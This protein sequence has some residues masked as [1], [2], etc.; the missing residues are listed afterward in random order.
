LWLGSAALVV[1]FGT[2]TWPVGAN[3][4]WKRELVCPVCSHEMAAIMAG[5]VLVDRCERHGVWLDPGE[6]GR[7]IGAPEAEE[8]AAF[9]RHVAPG[10]TMPELTARQKI[11]E[12]EREERRR[13]AEARAA[14]I[15]NLEGEVTRYVDKV[16]RLRAEL[17][18]AEMVLAAARRKRE[19]AN[20]T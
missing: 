1:A 3:A 16:R 15:P 20:D 13:E 19:G 14:Q 6:L 10:E 12:Q 9:Y 17:E 11:R 4:W 8:L 2:R 18:S 7:L 5:E